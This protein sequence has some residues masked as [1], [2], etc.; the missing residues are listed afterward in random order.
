[1]PENAQEIMGGGAP[2]DSTAKGRNQKALLNAWVDLLE[3]ENVL[4]NVIASYEVVP[5][6]GQYSPPINPQQLKNALISRTERKR[7]E[8]LLEEQGKISPENL[9]AAERKVE[10]CKGAERAKT[11]GRFFGDFIRYYRDFRRMEALIAAMD[12]INII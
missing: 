9:H 11:A 8:A 12:D 1:V 2:D 5:L 6:L 7:V 4:E 3:R 10:N